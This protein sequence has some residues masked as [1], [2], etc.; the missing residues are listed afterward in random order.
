MNCGLGH[1]QPLL[2]MGEEIGLG[3]VGLCCRVPIYS[4]CSWGCTLVSKP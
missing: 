4:V 2:G 3:V 1:Q